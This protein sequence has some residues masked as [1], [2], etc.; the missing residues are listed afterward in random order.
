MR[1]ASHHS[2]DHLKRDLVKNLSLDLYVQ[3]GLPEEEIQTILAEIEALDEGHRQK[4]LALCVS[5]SY[6]RASFVTRALKNIQE[7]SQYLSPEQMEGWVGT[8]FELLDQGIAKTLDFLAKTDAKSLKDFSTW[9][10]VY[11]KQVVTTLET[12][13]KGVSGLELRIEPSE[14]PYTDTDTIYL[15]SFVD[16]LERPQ[17]NF[18]LYKLM[19][20]HQWAQISQGTLHLNDKVLRRYLPPQSSPYCDIETLFATF[21]S[22]QF[23]VDLYT[24]LDAIRLDT[25]LK[26][27][28]PGL[29]REAKAV[30]SEFFAERPSIDSVSDKTA[31]VEGLYQYYLKGSV[32]GHLP[33]TLTKYIAAAKALRRARSPR[34]VLELL[35]AIYS[36]AQELEGLYDPVSFAPFL[37]IIKPKQVSASLNAKRQALRKRLETVISKL[38]AMPEKELIARDKAATGIAPL[39]SPKKGE[40]DFLLVKG[41]LFKLDQELKDLVEE[42]GEVFGG[43]LLEGN[44]LREGTA[45]WL[46]RDLLEDNEPASSEQ[47]IKY[48]EWDH[49]RAGYRKG[50]CSLFEQD[51]SPGQ[52]PFVELTLRRYWGYVKTLRRKFELL[53]KEPKIQRR[54]KEGDDLDIDAVVEAFSDTMAGLSPSEDLFVQLSREDRNIAALF[55]LDMSG[56]TKGWVNQAE[57]EALVLMCEALDALGDRYGIYGFSGLTRNKCEFYRIKSFEETYAEPIK[58]RIAGIIPKDFTRMGPPIRHSAH[59]LESIDARTKILVTLSDGRPEDWDAYKGNYGIE[60]TKKALLEAKEKGIHP[61]CITIDNEAS[62]YLPHMFGEINY[63]VL[64]DVRKLPDRITEIYRRLTA[65]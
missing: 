57:K 60:D 47:G 55:L 17:K 51:L 32:K 54:Q 40:G 41:R 16:R 65:R 63:I 61:F 38:T 12:Y 18:L 21:P 8:A 1:A 11:L 59:I 62:S 53:R 9:K 26:K 2:I 22:R 13:L 23:A 4:T 28:L 44:S 10:A 58:K 27:E 6:A 46:L 7:S 30:K 43:R 25:F 31:L 14:D 52:E 3:E 20:A 5:F 64:D 37:G 48:D 56:S 29:M 34:K 35:L 49:R 45:F 50:W 24:I 36:A 19:V 42:G 15:P 39:E 33:A